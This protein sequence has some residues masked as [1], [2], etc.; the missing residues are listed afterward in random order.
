MKQ[1]VDSIF[2]FC[3]FLFYF[4]F[5]FMFLLRLRQPFIARFSL[6]LVQTI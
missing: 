1:N 5:I 4:L 2:F 3:F 6:K